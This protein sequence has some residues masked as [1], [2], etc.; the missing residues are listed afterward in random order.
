M[1]KTYTTK[2]L[3]YETIKTLATR[4]D[5]A[6]SCGGMA[7]IGSTAYC[8]RTTKDD[9]ANVIYKISNINTKD[10]KVETKKSPVPLAHGN[11]LTVNK[12]KTSLFVAAAPDKEKAI[13]SIRDLKQRIIKLSVKDLS[14]TQIYKA[15]EGCMSIAYAGS[16]D[17][18]TKTGHSE[19]KEYL[20]YSH[21]K[22]VEPA[23]GTKANGTVE[24]KGQ[25]FYV[26]N[27]KYAEYSTPQDIAYRNGRLYVIL[28]NRPVGN[29]IWVYDL[30]KK[31]QSKHDGVPCYEPVEL[32]VSK[33]KETDYSIYEVE[34]LDFDKNGQLILFCN[35]KLPE[36]KG[37]VKKDSLLRTNYTA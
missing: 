5:G 35:M 14:C 37:S 11:G 34:S 18:I 1:A 3:T 4:E 23:K 31:A 33:K 19:N 16:N 15:K 36:N 21:V 22:V 24:S 8:I 20:K 9:S 26:H 30:S 10:G 13:D 27:P 12:D 6:N 29:I 7:I 32:L 28:W 2:L 25:D 17:F